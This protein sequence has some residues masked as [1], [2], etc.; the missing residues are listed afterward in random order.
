MHLLITF[1]GRICAFRCRCRDGP[2]QS[3]AHRQ[4]LHRPAAGVH[5][6]V[7]WSDV[8]PSDEEFREVHLGL[9]KRLLACRRLL[10]RCQVCC[11]TPQLMHAHTAAA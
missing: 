10:K 6:P 5:V 1:N 9:L 2:A 4:L 7:R 3:S 11:H 8:Q